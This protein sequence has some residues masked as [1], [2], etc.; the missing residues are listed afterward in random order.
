MKTWTEW[1]NIHFEVVC[2]ILQYF[3]GEGGW[4]GLEG[5]GLEGEGGVS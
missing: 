3:L 2:L 1:K 4:E 5:E